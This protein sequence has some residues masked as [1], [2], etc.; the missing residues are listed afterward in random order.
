MTVT[1][2]SRPRSHTEQELYQFLVT[3]QRQSSDAQP[4]IASISWDIP[5]TDPLIVLQALAADREPH[6]VFENRRQ[7]VAIAAVGSVAMQTIQTRHRFQAAQQFMQHCR[8]RSHLRHGDTTGSLSFFCSFTFFD[9]ADH[10][11]SAANPFPAA[12]LFVPRWQ[13]TNQGDRASFTANL[14]VAPT[15]DLT[16]LTQHTWATLKSVQTLS[17]RIVAL[18]HRYDTLPTGDRFRIL[19]SPS[20]NQFTQ[21]VQSVL[22][23]IAAGELQKVV[24]AHAFDVAAPQPFSVVRSLDNLRQRYPDCYVFATSNGKG[25]SFIGA[26]PER[27]LTIQDRAIVV[28]ALAGSSPRGQSAMEDQALGDR[29]LHHPKER[30]E[31][32]VVVDFIVQQLKQSGVTPQ[33]AAA[34]TLLRLSNIQHLHTPIHARL[35]MGLHPLDLL[36]QLHPTPAVAGLDRDRACQ[37]ILRHESF[38]RSLYAAPIGWLDHRGNSE[39]VVG[40]RSALLDGDRARLYAG[41]GIVAGSDPERELAEIRLKL[42]ALLQ[43]LV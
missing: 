28:D 32:Q 33:F 41:A 8:E 34:P 10:P 24:L 1:P 15:T 16:H 19:S 21:S 20:P 22:D 7:Q 27:L 17:S 3:C 37:K 6:F 43:A 12:T 2:Y 4:A 14:L 13:V 35:P 36:E 9:P 29:L 42:Q 39:F 40:I 18:C 26:S 25:Q 11:P 30:H 23:A 5:R 38:E 31:H